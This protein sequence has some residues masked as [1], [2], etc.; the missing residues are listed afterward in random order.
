MSGNNEVPGRTVVTKAS[1]ILDAFAGNRVS[2]SLS[3][4]AR[5]TGLPSSTVHRIARELVTWGGLERTPEGNYAVGIRLWEIAAR[6]RRN[7]GLRETAMP[8]LHGLF[9]LTR[10]H[11]QLAVMDGADALLIEKISAAHAVG[12]I[13]RVGGRLPLYASAVGKALLA[14]SPAE[15][16]ERILARRLPAY[17]P[18]TL[19][20]ARA[21]R[22]E[23]AETRR[24]GFALANEEMSVGAVSCAAAIPGPGREAVAAISVVMPAGEVPPRTWSP[25]V[26][27]AAFGIAR[28]LCQQRPQPVISAQLTGVQ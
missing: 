14:S 23:L 21:L 9:D 1:M 17:T 20:S 6:S 28:A 26:R 3:D 15:T 8:F 25:A 11:V 12:T 19:T 13:G 24:R 22:R 5:A 2:L 18:S 27:A 7:Y 16:Q 10:Q 4:L